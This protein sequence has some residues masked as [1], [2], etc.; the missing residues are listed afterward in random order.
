MNDKTHI[1]DILNE[2][3]NYGPNLRGQSLGLS[4]TVARPHH[5]PK[6]ESLKSKMDEL[7]RTIASSEFSE[8]NDAP[9]DSR[10]APVRQ[11]RKSKGRKESRGKEISGDD[12]AESRSNSERIGR[13]TDE[14]T[15]DIR[16]K[17]EVVC[18]NDQ[19]PPADTSRTPKRSLI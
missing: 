5:L 7:K 14:E 3:N 6:M 13:D 8:D 11:K 17:M 15:V 2:D 1:D 18:I 12:V 10:G 16:G 19:D 9:W 4:A